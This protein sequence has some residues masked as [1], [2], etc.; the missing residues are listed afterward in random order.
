MFGRSQ[1]N[2]LLNDLMSDP[3]GV[4]PVDVFNPY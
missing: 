2:Q 3:D 4:V 1:T